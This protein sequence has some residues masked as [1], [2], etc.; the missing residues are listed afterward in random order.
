MFAISLLPSFSRLESAFEC[1][2]Y[3]FFDHHGG[4]IKFKKTQVRFLQVLNPLKLIKPSCG[5]LVI[6]KI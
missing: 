1:K 5:N 4:R 3:L 6:F 2:I